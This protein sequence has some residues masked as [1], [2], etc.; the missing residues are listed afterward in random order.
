MFSFASLFPLVF[1]TSAPNA[2]C[3]NP[4][5]ARKQSA[6]KARGKIADNA[7]DDFVFRVRVIM[8]R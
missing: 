8:V 1:A 6:L 2:A 5:N 4:R 3:A 7:G